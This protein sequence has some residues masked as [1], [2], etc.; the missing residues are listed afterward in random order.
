MLSCDIR[1]LVRSS[2]QQTIK[3]VLESRL[4]Q[5]SKYKLCQYMSGS[6][7]QFWL[8]PKKSK[9]QIQTHLFPKFSFSAGSILAGTG[10]GSSVSPIPQVVK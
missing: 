8:L 7:T 5:N 3:R 9:I 4:T 6:S 2:G 10:R 1:E